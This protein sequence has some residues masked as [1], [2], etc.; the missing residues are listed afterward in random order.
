MSYRTRHYHRPRSSTRTKKHARTR[1]GFCEKPRMDPQLKPI[2]Q[3][4]GVP[5][6]SPFKPD[7]F[8]VEA[9]EGIRE[10]DVLVSAPTGSGKTWIATQAISRGLSQGLRT[11]YAS[12]LKALSNAIYQEFCDEFG[13]SA[14]GILTG[15]R[16]ENPGAPIIV[17]TTEILRNQLYDAM[18]EGVSIPTDL[19]ILDEAHYLSDPDRGVVWEEVLIY[20]P[21]R[22]RLLLLSA[23]IYN[24]EEIAAWLVENRA[25]K[26]RVVRS[27][28]RP[29]PL[30]MLFLFPDGLITPLAGKRGL[31]PRVKKFIASSASRG[32][33]KASANRHFGDVIRCLKAFDL[34]P[35]IFFLKSRVDCD[36]ALITCHEDE[37]KPTGFQE[38]FRRE[39]R[40]FIG[41]FP[42]LERH[43]QIKTLLKYRV[44]SHHAG[45]L[46]YWKMLIERM[47]VKGYLDAIFSTSTVAAGVNFPARTVVLVQ[48][49]KYDGRGFSNLTATDLHQMTGR[50]GRRGKDKIGFAVLVPGPHQDPQLINELKDSPPEPLASQIRINFS[51]TLNLLLSHSPEE[52]KDLLGRSFASFQRRQRGTLAQRQWEDKLTAL[53]ETLPRARCDSN[54]PYEVLEN[55]QKRAA[56]RKKTRRMRQELQEEALVSAYKKY[57]GPGRLILHKNRNIYVVFHTAMEKGRLVCSAHNLRRRLGTRKGRIRLRK[58]DIH[59]IKAILDYQV[60]MPEEYSVEILDKRFAAIPRHD[61]VPVHIPIPD[62]LRSEKA[63]ESPEEPWPESLPC[64]SCDHVK[65]CHGGK[66]GDLGPL[67]RDFR[68]QTHQMEV[69]PGGLWLSFKR[70]LRFL[71][72]TGFVD[73]LNTLTQDGQWAS[74]LRLDHPLL[75]AEAI[76]RGGLEGASPAIMAGCLAPFVWDRVQDLDLSIQSPMNLEKLEGAFSGM[77]DRIEDIRRTKVKRGFENPQFLFW[78][79]AALYL[80]TRGIDWDGL[81]HFIPVDEGDMASLI[82]RTA[83]HLRQVTNLADS[84]P[85]LSSTAERAIILIMREPV[86]IK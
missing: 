81:C 15:D 76:R 19:V 50:A 54:D 4:I 72:D 6:P 5:K 30:E 74:K 25:V 68:A 7:L 49:D 55:I 37:E 63:L 77:L 57:L 44:G 66:K 46:P 17:G 32:G 56:L 1:K 64:E 53:R 58:L 45:Q 2:F 22:V 41:R 9:L 85:A 78:P 34:L 10:W 86:F 40:D 69:L 31:I 24:A 23:T 13:H 42:H 70:H 36:R 18:H 20:L 29:V 47:M 38:R 27:H 73:R 8:Q 65:R 67:L 3:Q 21:A 51:M 79:A 83:D 16:K 84:H 28:E 39:V 59:Q 61:L 12:P 48:S 11:W 60:D 62:A 14:C 52:V 82:V 26:A 33:R 75:I 80:W 35:A 43:R 71:K